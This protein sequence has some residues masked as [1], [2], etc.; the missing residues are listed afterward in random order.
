MSD[1]TVHRTKHARVIE[2]ERQDGVSF[3]VGLNT[4][5]R[6]QFGGIHAVGTW[7]TLAEAAASAK[8]VDKL[9]EHA[10]MPTS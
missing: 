3:Q 2:R 5:A 8:T 4:E 9:M 1:R 6:R 7:A 10:G